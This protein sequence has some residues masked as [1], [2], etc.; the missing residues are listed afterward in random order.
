MGNLPN[1]K[2][3]SNKEELRDA[4]TKRYAGFKEPAVT[5]LA[6]EQPQTASRKWL[7]LAA[8]LPAAGMSVILGTVKVHSAEG[9]DDVT[10]HYYLQAD[11]SVALSRENSFLSGAGSV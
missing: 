7:F 4:F 2:N 8:T 3:W 11:R 5:L 6:E 9:G 10:G 1:V